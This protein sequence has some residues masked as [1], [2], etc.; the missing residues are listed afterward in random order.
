VNINLELDI[1]VETVFSV[2]C[3]IPYLQFPILELYIDD[4]YWDTVNPVPYRSCSG[5][6]YFPTLDMSP[7]HYYYLA[8]LLH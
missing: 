7:E 6:V 1:T 2:A 4:K 3:E 5:A 8:N